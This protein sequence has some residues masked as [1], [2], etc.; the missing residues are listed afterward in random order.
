MEKNKAGREDGEA[1]EGRARCGRRKK[2]QQEVAGVTSQGGWGE[3]VILLHLCVFGG[4]GGAGKA[5]LQAGA[6]HEC[7]D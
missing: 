3:K 4:G 1:R 5:S 2:I 7:K 6:Q